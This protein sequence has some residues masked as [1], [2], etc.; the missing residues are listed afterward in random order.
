MKILLRAACLAAAVLAAWGAARTL[1]LAVGVARTPG[2]LA[3]AW[4]GAPAARSLAGVR[5]ARLD[6][7]P[8]D[9]V[10]LG[11]LRAAVVMVYEPSCRVCAA[12]MASWTDLARG[13]PDGAPLYALGFAKAKHADVW[14]YWDGMHG[15]VRVLGTDTATLMRRV[16]VRATPATLVVRN[17]V[18]VH[19]YRSLLQPHARQTLLRVLRRAGPVALR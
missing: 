14:G 19:E 8:G 13:A 7:A 18:V 10:D 11:S 15:R 2:V 9:S 4:D 16:G 5:V 17:G 12:T 6:G 3:R 1:R